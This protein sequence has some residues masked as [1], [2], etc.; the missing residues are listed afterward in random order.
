[1]SASTNDV[2]LYSFT[3]DKVFAPS[4]G[5]DNVFDEVAEF[6]QSAIDGYHVCIFSYGQ[7]GSGKTH[8][9]REFIFIIEP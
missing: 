2:G 1:M 8:T 9:V 6:V 4:A 3:F 7:T 5:Q